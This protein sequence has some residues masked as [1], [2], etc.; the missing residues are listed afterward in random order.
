M[1]SYDI[2]RDT[3][4]DMMK[5]G[6]GE[7]FVGKLKA[8]L[9][10]LLLPRMTKPSDDESFRGIDGPIQP[11]SPG[12][13]TYESCTVEGLIIHHECLMHNTGRDMILV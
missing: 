6:G 1:D 8:T 10:L 13:Q 4:L 12:S 3:Y 9:R 5:E 7:E 2:T 11:Q